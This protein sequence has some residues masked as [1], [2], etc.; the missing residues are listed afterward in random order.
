MDAQTPLLTTIGYE[1][2]SLADFI[3]TLLSAKV[4]RLIDVRELPISRRKGFAKNALSTA[5][6]AAG[7]EYIHLKGLGDPKVGRDAARRKDYAKFT[8]I[9]TAH[10]RTDAAQ[11]DLRI[12][13]ELAKAG[14]SCLMCFE[15]DPHHCHRT[16]VATAVCDN[17]PL[18]VRHLGVR[19]GV[20]ALKSK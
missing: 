2:S 7:I 12:A 3:E 8:K 16:F 6:A 13:V 5:L 17:L 4:R 20:A 14:G 1:G 9:F 18:T 19:T 15:R 10:M 11:S